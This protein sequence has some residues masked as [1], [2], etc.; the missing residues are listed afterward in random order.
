MS[1]TINLKQVAYDKLKGMI[2]SNELAPNSYL[3]EKKLCEMM[4]MSRT[5][6][7][8][9]V[10]QLCQEDFVQTIQ[11]KGIFVTEIS[12]QRARELFEMRYMIEPLVLKLAFDTIDSKKLRE[13]SDK[14]DEAMAADDASTLN[15][16]DY[17]IHN[18]FT[19]CCPNSMLRKTAYNISDHFQRIRTMSFY[20]HERTTNGALE[21]FKLFEL[22]NERKLKEAM[23][24]LAVHIHSTESF[25]LRSIQ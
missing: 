2:L 6:I 11:N 3:E 15:D 25:Y 12:L 13:F 20:S 1:T 19:Y 9:A 21:H 24:F 16:L 4:G 22:I 18:Y 23:D 5:P 17:Q 7:R 10:N 8:E 14:T